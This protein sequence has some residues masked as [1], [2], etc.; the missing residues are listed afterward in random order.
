[1]NRFKD[2]YFSTEISR[3]KLLRHTIGCYVVT[4]S[5]LSVIFIAG[6]YFYQAGINT[7]LK[8]VPFVLVLTVIQ[9]ILINYFHKAVS[10]VYYVREAFH[11]LLLALNLFCLYTAIMIA[12]H[13][14]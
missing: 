4:L 9:V 14:A 3:A 8:F 11:L 10:V 2:K 5:T 13:G 6:L 12:G 7:V 1:V